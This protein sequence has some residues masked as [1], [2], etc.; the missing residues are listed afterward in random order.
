MLTRFGA[1][2]LATLGPAVILFWAA[3]LARPLDPAMVKLV[4]AIV[5]IGILPLL[6]VIATSFMLAFGIDTDR[7]LPAWYRR[8]F[9]IPVA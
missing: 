8:I 1:W 7:Y 4:S 6:A 9:G 2:Y 5:S 3:M